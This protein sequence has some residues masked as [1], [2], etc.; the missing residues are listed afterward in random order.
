MQTNLAL[1]TELPPIDFGVTYFDAIGNIIHVEILSARD[2]VD[3]CDKARQF[4][5]SDF[6]IIDDPEIVARGRE[7]VQEATMN[8]VRSHRAPD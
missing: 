4:P 8:I 1:D 7:A 5:A 6:Q 3:A 2:A